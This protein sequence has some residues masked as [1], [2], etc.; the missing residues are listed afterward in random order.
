M[1]A[2]N[3]LH[4]LCYAGLATG[5]ATGWFGAPGKRAGRTT[6]SCAEV[7]ETVTCR[8]P[9]SSYT[10]LAESDA[11]PHLLRS[12]SDCCT[13]LCPQDSMLPRK[14]YATRR[15]ANEVQQA[16]ARLQI[17]GTP[18]RWARDFTMVLVLKMYEWGFSKHYHVPLSVPALAVNAN[19]Q[20]AGTFD[21]LARQ[22]LQPQP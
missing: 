1:S 9:L 7:I 16:H 4:L 5:E 10:L 20:F 12:P 19:G 17:A 8:Q 15:Y 14:I 13:G 18:Q 6:G 2:Y 22:A 11:N 21:W 3:Q